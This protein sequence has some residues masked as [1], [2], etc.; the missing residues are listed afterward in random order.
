MT[1][2]NQHKSLPPD[3]GSMA[4]KVE[5]DHAR[6]SALIWTDSGGGEVVSADDYRKLGEQLAHLEVAYNEERST[7]MRLDKM[8]EDRAEQ[9]EASERKWLIGANATREFYDA[10]LTR[11][12]EQL[13]ASQK[14]LSRA[15]A[16]L[17]DDGY[18]ADPDFGPAYRE[19]AA[20]LVS[21]PAKERS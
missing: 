6:H 7:A 19:M 5:F 1:A 17:D 15:L 12:E 14:A 10:K 2:S 11:L 20:A 16:I 4:D 18:Q 3:G 21:I 8:L 9:Y 13:E